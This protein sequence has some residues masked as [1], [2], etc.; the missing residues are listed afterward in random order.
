VNEEKGNWEQV[1]V[2]LETTD[3]RGTMEDGGGMME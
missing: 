2:E 3:D 1:A